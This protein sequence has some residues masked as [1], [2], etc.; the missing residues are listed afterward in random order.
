[1]KTPED[2]IKDIKVFC[3]RRN[4]SKEGTYNY[5]ANLYDKLLDSEFKQTQRLKNTREKRND[6]RAFLSALRQESEK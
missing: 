4:M 2:Y 6:L 3:I 5:C 1:M